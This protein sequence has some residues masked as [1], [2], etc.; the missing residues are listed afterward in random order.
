MPPQK[1]NKSRSG[2]PAPRSPSPP[3]S[4]LD[5]S[6]VPPKLNPANYDKWL[7]E[8]QHYMDERYTGLREFVF[9]NRVLPQIPGRMGLPS[10]VEVRKS[11]DGMFRRALVRAIPSDLWKVLPYGLAKHD[12]PAEIMAYLRTTFADGALPF[13]VRTARDLLRSRDKGQPVQDWLDSFILAETRFSAAVR[14][15]TGCLPAETP[16]FLISLLA[17]AGSRNA[18]I[19]RDVSE[20]IED[21]RREGMPLSSPL[22][23]ARLLDLITEAEVKS[24]D[25]DDATSLQIVTFNQ[26]THSHRRRH[27]GSLIYDPPL[28]F[29]DLQDYRYVSQA[30]SWR[31]VAAVAINDLKATLATTTI[32]RLPHEVI[33]NLDHVK[34]VFG[35]MHNWNDHREPLLHACKI[36]A[37]ADPRTHHP[38][39]YDPNKMTSHAQLDSLR[40]LLRVFPEKR[41]YRYFTMNEAFHSTRLKKPLYIVQPD[42][43]PGAR[44]RRGF[45]RV[46]NCILGADTST[47]HTR[48]AAFLKKRRILQTTWDPNVFLLDTA[49]TRKRAAAVLL[50]DC[51]LLLDDDWDAPAIATNAVRSA[52]PRAENR[53]AP[54]TLLGAE[55]VFN[56]DKIL[57]A[58]R[59]R[60]LINTL[61][62]RFDV[63]DTFDAI[64]D[65]EEAR[66]GYSDKDFTAMVASLR[67]LASWSRPDMSAPVAQL[68]ASCSKPATEDW[69]RL[70]R[71]L[72]RLS[73]TRD[74]SIHFP[75]YKKFKDHRLN[76]FVDTDP[77]T[78]RC[79]VAIGAFGTLVA[80]KT[81]MPHRSLRRNDSYVTF[82]MLRVAD[83]IAAGVHARVGSLTA[84]LTDQDVRH[85]RFEATR[86]AT[87]DL[88]ATPRPSQVSSLSG[89]LD[90]GMFGGGTLVKSTPKTLDPPGRFKDITRRHEGVLDFALRFGDGRVAYNAA[91][92]DATTRLF[93]KVGHPG[94]L[95]SGRYDGPLEKVVGTYMIKSARKAPENQK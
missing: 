8:F 90:S 40:L 75:N 48:V 87:T 21:A 37:V 83:A 4:G 1:N 73:T 85:F 63:H 78:G 31:I 19:V 23:Y 76:V 45:A 52:F 47:W 62:E 14:A 56:E 7:G 46:D 2:R 54:K 93:Y 44:R 10:M 15:A 9:E 61:F 24:Q 77:E 51:L 79:G 86:V 67:F 35:K 41:S 49:T 66:M 33:G 13:L 71:A 53:G 32:H 5:G 12:S 64:F 6:M 59:S 25:I 70:F 26:R 57:T 30:D 27:D 16:K 20:F 92:V 74:T 65:P 50:D 84:G 55:L 38:F 28:S 81:Y 94:S 82:D 17:I 68:S 89:M 88:L 80:W 39:Y 95:L 3:A 69:K 36:V 72:H 91:V 58:L 42:A 22:S 11:L 34:F 43:F 18:D 60:T 29:K